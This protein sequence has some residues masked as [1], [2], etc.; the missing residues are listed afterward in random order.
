MICSLSFK[1]ISANVHSCKFLGW[2]RHFPG[3]PG[4]CISITS[5]TSLVRPLVMWELMSFKHNNGLFSEG[6]N[7]SLS[8]NYGLYGTSTYV[9]VMWD[10]LHRYVGVVGEYDCRLGLDPGSTNGWRQKYVDSTAVVHTLQTAWWYVSVTVLSIYSYFAWR[11]S[12]CILR[13]SFYKS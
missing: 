7:V 4:P 9:C 10:Y 12:E 8:N 6:I 2:F 13:A 11:I 1:T 5:E 3:H